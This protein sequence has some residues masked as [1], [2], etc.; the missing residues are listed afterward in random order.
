MPSVVVEAVSEH[1]SQ[2]QEEDV[3]NENG[4]YRVRGLHPKCFYR[5]VLKTSEGQKM[6]SYPAHYDIMVCFAFVVIRC[7]IKCK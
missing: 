3:T 2:L 4:D 1:C 6:Q 7:C 5:L